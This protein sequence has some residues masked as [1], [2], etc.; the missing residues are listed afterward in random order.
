MRIALANWSSRL[1]G[2]AE[3]YL[4]SIARPLAEL[5]HDLALFA[6]YDA[7]ADRDSIPVADGSAVWVVADLG[8]EAALQGLR[9]WKPDVIYVNG[10]DSPELEERL[11]GIAPAVLCGHS[12][13]GTC[14]SGS[15]TLSLPETVPCERHFGS[16]CLWLYYPRRCGGLN[17][18]TMARD[19][20]RQ[21]RRLSLLARYRGVVTLS[22][23]MRGEYVRH[24]I[25]A[26]TVAVVPPPIERH[27]VPEHGGLEPAEGHLG[28]VVR[29]LFLGRLDRLKGGAVLLDALPRVVAA[30]GRRVKLTFAGDGPERSAWERRAA[31][32]MQH[33]KELEIE[34][35]GWLDR[36]RIAQALSST[37]LLVMP[38]LWP[39]PF[40]LVGLEAGLYGVPTA[41]FDVGGIPEWLEDGVNGHMAVN[42]PASATDLGEAIV[43][44][45][46]DPAHYAALRESAIRVAGGYTLERH[47]AR[48]GEV[49]E[50]AR[51]E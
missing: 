9:D 33:T 12:Y 47:L 15:K 17:P 34:F 41:A 48:L 40:G 16:T 36:S 7:P 45:L 6:E 29:L 5:G 1:A 42:A 19:Y 51:R 24:G 2:G 32:L 13:Y 20:R 28:E 49:F 18:Q 46:A 44:C 22:E 14:I 8:T 39:E 38:S 26:G 50:G 31:K 4:G 30:L 23:H 11:L 10:I 21:Q 37:H 3:T 25:A 43:S 35:A 27:D